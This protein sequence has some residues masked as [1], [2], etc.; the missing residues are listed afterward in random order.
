[1]DSP[2]YEFDL[3]LSNG[4][5]PSDNYQ[6]EHGATGRLGSSL[7]KTSIHMGSLNKSTTEIY[8]FP[9][10]EGKRPSPA[11]SDEFLQYTPVLTTEVVVPAKQPNQDT[12]TG[13]KRAKFETIQEFCIEKQTTPL[14]NLIQRLDSKGGISDL[15]TGGLKAD[16]LYIP[17]N[18]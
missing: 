7:K 4:P 2:G 1:M 14:L 13:Q 18:S 12:P 3:A 5:T 8:D 15:A 6:L 11:I 17:S 16:H 9:A 10:I